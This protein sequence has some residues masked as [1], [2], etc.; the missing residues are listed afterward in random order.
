MKRQAEKK[1]EEESNL[2]IEIQV[3]VLDLGIK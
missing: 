1:I 2:G 3:W